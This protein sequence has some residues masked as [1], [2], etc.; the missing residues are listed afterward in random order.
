MLQRLLLLSLLICV[1]L[2]WAS[3]QEEVVPG[4]NNAEATNKTDSAKLNKGSRLKL[5]MAKTVYLK[6]MEEEPFY[7]SYYKFPNI[8]KTRYYSDPKTEQKIFDLENKAKVDYRELSRVLTDYVSKFGIDNFKKGNDL[9]YVWKLAQ[10]RE[11][12]QDTAAALFYYSIALKNN[13]RYFNEIQIQYDSLRALKHNEK[14]DLDYYYKIVAARL[15]VDTLAPPKGVLLKMGEEVNTLYPDYAPY[16]H[17]S[18]NAL[19]FSS[20][21]S[22]YIPLGESDYM[23]LQEDI[24]YS[25]YDFI[26][27]RWERAEPFGYPIKTQYNEG[28]ACLDKDGTTLFFVRCNSPDGYG[29]C[30]LY[31]ADYV[32]GDWTNVRNMGPTINSDYWDSHPSVTPDGNRL[33]FTSNR[34]GGFGRTDIYTST[35][36]NRGRW[37]PARNLGPIINTIED[38]ITPH[39]HQINNTLYF[40]STGQVTNYGGFDI[41][42]SRM[43]GDFYEEPINL[44]PL[45]N[46]PRDEYYF[47]IDGTGDSLYYANAQPGNPRNFDL[48]SFPMPMGARPD[49]VTEL[50]GYLIDSVT[51]HPLTGIVAAIDLDQNVEIEPLFINKVGFFKFRLVNERNYMLL[52]LGENAIR[53]EEDQMLESDSLIKT[54]VE[55]ITQEQSVIFE[56]LEFQKNTIAITSDIRPQLDMIVDFMNDHPYAKLIIRGHTDSD[57]NPDYNMKL[58]RDRANAI[59]KYILKK[60]MLPESSIIAEGYGE[61]MPVF[62]ND[63]E[64]HKARNRRVEFEFI[65]P[66]QHKGQFRE[67][68]GIIDPGMVRVLDEADT[69]EVDTDPFEFLLDGGILN[70]EDDLELDEF[71]DNTDPFSEMFMEEDLAL[72][73]EMDIDMFDPE[74]PDSVASDLEGADFEAEDDFDDADFENDMLNMEEFRTGEIIEDDADALLNDMDFGDDKVEVEDSAVAPDNPEEFFQGFEDE[75]S[76]DFDAQEDELEMGA[77]DNF[78]DLL[79]V[80]DELDYLMLE[81]ENPFK[82][83]ADELEK[84]SEDTAPDFSDIEAE[85]DVVEDPTEDAE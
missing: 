51:G 19:L 64:A 2:S 60:T 6:E 1:C 79:D 83:D 74:N 36:D 69:A 47:S 27:E 23:N 81:Y 20:R 78:E 37:T 61:T 49:A 75:F 24:Y 58:S 13:S 76:F 39:Y 45:I 9:D 44:G 35:R 21:R 77:W 62:P 17:P 28:S 73:E 55:S 70:V 8:N 66:A 38:E 34:P 12:L 22:E 25:L 14:V 40:S 48:Y 80:G 3:A 15:R 85:D 65:I 41:F 29:E 68:V 4:T 5:K 43:S 18:G 30:D 56:G 26:N 84:A 59:R 7:R 50:S 11:I 53:V 42:K 67:A 63:S 57:G 32:N 52:V 10:V 16:M 82:Y 72:E 31:E 54:F 71:E 33:F 46:T